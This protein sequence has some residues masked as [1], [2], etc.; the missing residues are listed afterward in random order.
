MLQSQIVTN[1]SVPVSI[2]R[3]VLNAFKDTKGFGGLE[4]A[5]VETRPKPSDFSGRKNPQHASL[6]KGSKAVCPMS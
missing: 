6:G 2:Y 3:T 1:P 4:V 5:W